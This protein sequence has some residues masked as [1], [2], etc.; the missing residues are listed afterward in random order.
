MLYPLRF[1]PIYMEKVWGGRRLETILGRELP[2]EIPV[3]ESWEVSD[4][5]HGKSVVANGAEQGKTLDALIA[6]YGAALL[7]TRAPSTQFPL[8]VKYIDA[9]TPL[10]VQVHPDDAYAAE[11]AGELGK[12]EMWYVLYAEPG[13]SLIAGLCAQVTREE[14]AEALAHG[15]PAA[16]LH[17]V[18]VTT[19]D[20]LFIP[21]GRIHAIMPGLLILEIQQNSDTTYR[22]YDWGRVGLDGQPRALHTAEAMAVTNWGDYTPQPEI[23]SREQAGEN[24][25]AVLAACPYFVVEKYDIA[26]PWTLP[27]DAGSFRILN[28]VAGG[29]TLR[30]EGGEEPL[31]VGDSLL[32]PAALDAVTLCPEY[33]AVFVVSYVP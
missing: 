5:P 30:W 28:C 11:H 10:S 22:L 15:D 29:G 24:I 32:L 2:P 17:Q 31:A 8:L 20:S 18:P 7:G 26:T 21:A 25:H 9:E 3:G 1:A 12:T 16:L 27:A 33:H 14:F 23:V 19:G 4:H 6:R 13:A